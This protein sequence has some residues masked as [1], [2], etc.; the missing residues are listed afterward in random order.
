MPTAGQNSFRN[1]G[2]EIGQ[3]GIEISERMWHLLVRVWW[4]NHA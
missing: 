3:H 1:F 4:W 2:V